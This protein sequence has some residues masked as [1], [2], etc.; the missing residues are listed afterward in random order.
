MKKIV[1]CTEKKKYSVLIDNFS[2]A[3]IKKIISNNSTSDRYFV[4]IDENVNRLHQPGKFEQGDPGTQ[5]QET[6]G[7]PHK[8]QW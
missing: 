8:I 1:A 7:N 2:P 4:V 6:G 5:P 3:D